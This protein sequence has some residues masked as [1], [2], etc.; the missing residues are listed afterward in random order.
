MTLRFGTGFVFA[1]TRAISSSTSGGTGAGPGENRY[2][3]TG[4][5]TNLRCAPA[6][7][8]S[9]KKAWCPLVSGA[10]D[11][12]IA[13]AQ[14]RPLKR[15]TEPPGTVKA[16]SVAATRYSTALACAPGARVENPGA[17]GLRIDGCR[18]NTKFATAR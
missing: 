1:H 7:G 11:P 3:F 8:G 10:P 17:P 6:L 14:M 2:F 5:F 18:L 15:I 13:Q 16:A 4:L 12:E 9:Q